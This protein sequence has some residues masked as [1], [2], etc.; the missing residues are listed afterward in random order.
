MVVSKGSFAAAVGTDC[1]LDHLTSSG[2][3][4]LHACFHALTCQHLPLVTGSA[5]D[6]ATENPLE[7]TKQ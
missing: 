4:V 2:Q 7:I 1:G 5:L 6:E 3:Q